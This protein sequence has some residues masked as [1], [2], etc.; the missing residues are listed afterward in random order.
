M[1]RKFIIDTDTASDD[2]VALVMAANHP[3][4]EIEAITIVAGNVPVKQGTQ[5]ALYTLKLCGK[6][7][8]VYTG[9]AKPL[10]RELST[11][12]HVHGKDGMSD[13]GLPLNGFRP[14]NEHAVDIIKEKINAN[15]NEITLVCM[16]P[17]T[18]IATAL[19]MDNTLVD[20][21]KKCVIMGGVGKGRG[22]V[23]P[24][25]EYNFWAD[26]EAAKVVFES[27]I[28][29]KM[30]GW[31]ISRKYAVFTEKDVKKLRKIGTPLA[32]FSIDIQKTLIE[33][34]KTTTHLD[35]FDLPDPIAM[36]IA[37]DPSIAIKTKKAYVSILVNDDYSRGQSVLDFVGSTGK[38]ANTEVVLEADSKKFRELLHNSLSLKQP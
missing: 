4:I 3:K 28:P 10:I 35:G 34:V 18:N 25:S 30:V 11:A 31:D 14:E 23:T 16:G 15:P 29:I 19:S 27:G 13:I 9:L 22:N 37:L 17:L 12:D 20:K 36:A 26:P 2:A 5:N 24:I 1:K 7:I 32:N 33:Y 38:A 21:I 6:T 8:P